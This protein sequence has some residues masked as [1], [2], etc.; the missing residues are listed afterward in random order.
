MRTYLQ[1][2]VEDIPLESLP[3][4]WKD[5]D[6]VSFSNQKRLYDFQQQALENTLKAL[7]LFYH[8]CQ[9]QKHDLFRRYQQN[10]LDEVG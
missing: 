7:Y 2:I 8:I 6:F 5:F 9:G 1:D 3:A 10:G 4:V